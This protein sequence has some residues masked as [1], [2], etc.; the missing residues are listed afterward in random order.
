MARA[1]RDTTTDP[2]GESEQLGPKEACTGDVCYSLREQRSIERR[3][4]GEPPVEVFRLTQAQFSD[5]STTCTNPQR[6]VLESIAT[7]G[8]P[9]QVTAVASLGAAGVQVISPTGESTRV[10][11]LEAGPPEPPPNRG[12][13]YASMVFGP[14]LA[15]GIWLAMRTRW[16]SWQAAIVVALAGWAASFSIAGVA[17]FFELPRMEWW[18]GAMLALTLLLTVAVGRNPRF[19]RRP[20]AVLSPPSTQDSG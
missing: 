4:D 13:V 20:D 14:V 18:L 8:P 7:T 5:I 11:V 1:D 17:A 3:V 19:G 6:G 12:L 9:D 16:P 15:V 10:P 2:Y